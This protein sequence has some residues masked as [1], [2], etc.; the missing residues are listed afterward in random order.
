MDVYGLSSL[1]DMVGMVGKVNKN[2]G[3]PPP[4]HELTNIS[5]QIAINN[6]LIRAYY[7]LVKTKAIKLQ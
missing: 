1:I 6:I 2:G 5:E 3:D 7:M 4:P